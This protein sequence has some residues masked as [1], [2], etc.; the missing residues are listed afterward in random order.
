MQIVFAL[1]PASR[2]ASLL[3]SR[4]KQGHQNRDDCDNDKQ[5]DQ[6]ERSSTNL[7]EQHKAGLI[8]FAGKARRG[9]TT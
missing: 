1:C 9:K 7:W 8:K 5:L 4:Q 2:F 3:H 6:R